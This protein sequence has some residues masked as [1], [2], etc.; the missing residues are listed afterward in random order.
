MKKKIE[1]KPSGK[2][3][4]VVWDH[5]RM[6]AVPAYWDEIDKCYKT[7]S[8]PA[9]TPPKK[10][11]TLQRIIRGCGCVLVRV[12]NSKSRRAPRGRT[13]HLKFCEKHKPN[14]FMAGFLAGLF[15]GTFGLGS[16]LKNIIE[17]KSD[18]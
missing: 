11:R 5:K 3:P 12:P 7:R 8:V 2:A 18:E 9:D 10:T 17:G 16:K 1:I 14:L 4:E 15:F 13:R 6:K